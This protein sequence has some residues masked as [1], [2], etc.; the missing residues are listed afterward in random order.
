M[1][2]RSKKEITEFLNRFHDF[3]ILDDGGEKYYF[4]F[5]EK[6]TGNIVTLMKYKDNS[7]TINRRNEEWHDNGEF[8]IT[9][10]DLGKL[11]WENHR[12]INKNIQDV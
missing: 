11:I 12:E 10:E 5:D 1:M 8:S 9:R 6:A 7:F 4:C 3:A 2:I